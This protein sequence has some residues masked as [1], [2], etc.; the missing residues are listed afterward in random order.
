MAKQQEL[1]TT[2]SL[3]M[4]H[5]RVSMFGCQIDAVRMPQAVDR[6]FEWITAA[7]GKCRYVVTPN[8]DHVVQLQHDARLRSCL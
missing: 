7:S 3:T 6:V 4:L 8:V 1:S 2:T 5:T